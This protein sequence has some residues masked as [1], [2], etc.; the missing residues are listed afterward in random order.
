VAGLMLGTI[1]ADLYTGVPRFSFGFFEL[2]ESVSLVALAMGIFGVSEVIATVRR[3]KPGDIDPKSVTMRAMIPTRDDW[4]QSWGPMLRGSAIGTFFGTLPGTGPSIAAF[5]SYAMEK[6]VAAKPELFGK[7]AIQGIMGPESANNAADQ[8]AFIPTLT[9]GIPGSASMAL[10]L[11]A[12]MIHGISPGP[13]LLSEQPA[14]FWGLVMSF[15][16]GNLI[17]LVLNIPLIG[18]WVRLL[19][20]PYNMLYPA[21]LMFVC[22]GTYSVNN[23]VFDVGMVVVFGFLG[24]MMRIFEWPAAPLLL[25]FVLG[26]MMENHFRR[27]MLLSRGEFATF[28]ES[29]ISATAI[30]LTVAVL[31]WGIWSSRKHRRRQALASNVD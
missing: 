28:I 8:T 31:L 13:G 22:I 2:T 9:L 4:R 19:M 10:M 12:L 5:M 30:G 15:W 17:L 1:G 25:G 6:R 11:G 24:Y 27:A 20:I 3:I 23:S 21:I 26:P 7:G 18:I 14:L 29:P 16:I